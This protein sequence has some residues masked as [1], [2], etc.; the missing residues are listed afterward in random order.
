MKGFGLVRMRTILCSRHDMDTGNVKD[1]HP[2]WY[3]WSHSFSRSPHPLQRF[4][5]SFLGR[6]SI[7]CFAQGDLSRKALPYFEITKGM[8]TSRS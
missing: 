4:D 3:L 7:C 1:I 8:G 6:S 5:A 2:R